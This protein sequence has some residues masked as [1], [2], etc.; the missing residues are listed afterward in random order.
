MSAIGADSTGEYAHYPT[1]AP[2]VSTVVQD[3]MA[4]TAVPVNIC[5]GTHHN[6]IGITNIQVSVLVENRYD[7]QESVL[8]WKLKNIKEWFQLKAKTPAS[9]GGVSYVDRNINCLQ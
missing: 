4:V 7:S 6:I 3:T 1:E 8:Y 5:T 9:R 2:Q